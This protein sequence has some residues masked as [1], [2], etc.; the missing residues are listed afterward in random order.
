M[1]QTGRVWLTIDRA[2]TFPAIPRP[3]KT[4]Y[5]IYHQVWRCITEDEHL[6]RAQWKC[7]SLESKHKYIYQAYQDM[8]RFLIQRQEYK[9]LVIQYY[10]DQI[11]LDRGSGMPFLVPPHE[12]E[13]DDDE[14]DRAFFKQTNSKSSWNLLQH[15]SSDENVTIQQDGKHILLSRVRLLEDCKVYSINGCPL[16]YH[17][18]KMFLHE[19]RQANQLYKAGINN[20]FT[21]KMAK[22]SLYDFSGKRL[23]FEQVDLLF[24][25]IPPCDRHRRSRTPSSRTTISTKRRDVF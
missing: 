3:P 10:E 12:D 17:K 11:L 25:N 21:R 9:Y 22:Q 15:P 8:K 23:S 2:A 18:A 16:T 5:S 24:A 13:D 20:Q 19:Q 1:D 7:L 6:I 14:D 4:P